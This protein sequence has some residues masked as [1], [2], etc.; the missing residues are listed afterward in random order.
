MTRA[1]IFSAITAER[2]R[3]DEKHPVAFNTLLD[4][5]YDISRIS[6]ECEADELKLKNDKR[7][8]WG[9]SSAFSLTLEELYEFFAETDKARQVEEAIQNAALWVRIIEEITK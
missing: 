2:A 3:Q 9:K 4:S 7:E 8:K 1:D 6:I 5:D